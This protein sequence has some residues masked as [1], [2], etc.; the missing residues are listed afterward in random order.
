[1]RVDAA[2]G[3][4]LPGDGPDPPDEP[5]RQRVEERSFAGRLH[6]D[7]PVGL[8]H[9]RGDLGEVLGA[10]RAD[11]DRQPDLGA[12]ALADAVAD[13]LCRTEQVDRA[14]DVEE[15]LVDGDALHERR[16]VAEHRHHLVGQAAGTPRSGRA[17]MSRSGQSRLALHPDI[18][19]CTPNCFAS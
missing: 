8:G 1:M 5:D 4:S 16:E 19:P 17:R 2:L 7:Q 12:H 13:D 6:H 14:G 9:L 10:G 11:R 15:R 18:P 3:E